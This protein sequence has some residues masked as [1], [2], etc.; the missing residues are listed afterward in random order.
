MGKKMA[1]LT[2][3]E[4]L[5]TET[6]YKLHKEG[7]D[8]SNEAIA[9]RISLDGKPML[10]DTVQAHKTNIYKKL[11][12]TGNDQEKM[13]KLVAKLE[14]MYGQRP[15]PRGVL[16]FVAV[17]ALA[18]YAVYQFAPR[19]LVSAPTITSRPSDTEQPFETPGEGQGGH[20]EA[21]LTFTP[22]FTSIPLTFTPVSP[23]LTPTITN[24][25]TPT[26]TETLAPLP[27]VSPTEVPLFED[28]FSSNTL[29]G[30]DRQDDNSYVYDGM[31][32]TDSAAELVVGDSSWT[33]YQ[34][35]FTVYNPPCGGYISYVGVRAMD[36]GNQMNL[37]YCIQWLYWAEI[38]N[39]NFVKKEATQQN[40]RVEKLDIVITVRGNDYQA[41]DYPVFTTDK[42]P[43]G[44]IYIKFF[45]PA[46]IDNFK[47]IQLP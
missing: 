2:R 3:T 39:G 11:D 17:L 13:G 30:W 29:E 16:V 5:I 21:V 9:S 19:T 23:T 6:I 24:T 40:F 14:E 41:M 38:V 45:H 32:R 7:K 27:T 42:F 46:T 15:I 28:D 43:S 35:S 4:K 34:V 20:P 36:K 12:I 33:N 47:V 37:Q 26:I 8:L 31:L 44:K 22:T 10:A 18:L 25:S 1:N